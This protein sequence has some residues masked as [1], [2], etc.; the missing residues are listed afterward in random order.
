[1]GCPREYQDNEE[2]PDRRELPENFYHYES[3]CDRAEAFPDWAHTTL[4]DH[5]RDS[6]ECLYTRQHLKAAPRAPA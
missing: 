5:A 4:V 3:P 6:G 2:I 1:M